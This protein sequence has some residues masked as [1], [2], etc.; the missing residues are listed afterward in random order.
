[1]HTDEVKFRDGAN[2]LV[3]W[4]I[5]VVITFFV[6]VTVVGK[7]ENVTGNA[8]AGIGSRPSASPGATSQSPSVN[9]FSDTLLRTNPQNA[10]QNAGN[11]ANAGATGGAAG[12]NADLR[13]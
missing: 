5:G 13:Q 7:I 4:A 8:A 6:L 3:V 2:G 11:G 9:Y 12:S 10:G 1:M